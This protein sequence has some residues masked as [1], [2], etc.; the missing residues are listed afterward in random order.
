M[1]RINAWTNYDEKQLVELEQ[2]CKDYRTFL[3]IGKTE[4]ECVKEIIKQ[5]EAN[6]YQDLDTV[7]KTG[8]KLQAGD[9]VYR[10]CMKKTVVMFQIGSQPLDAGMNILGAHI[11]SPRLDVKQNPL[12]ENG[13]FAYLDTHYY[14]GIKKYQWVAI[15]LAMY[16]VI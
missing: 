5:A 3:N 2:I 1:E 7:T 16:G 6:G 4:R 9:K 12:Y 15:P 10:V 11:D 14:G 8:K 13:D